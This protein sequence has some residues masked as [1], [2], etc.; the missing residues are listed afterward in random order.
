MKQTM[1][2]ENNDNYHHMKK[3]TD[4][5]AL[6]EIHEVPWSSSF[7]LNSQKVKE[8]HRKEF[9]RYIKG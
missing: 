2:G 9:K 1:G 7:K 3:Q 6:D 8:L 5:N 4:L